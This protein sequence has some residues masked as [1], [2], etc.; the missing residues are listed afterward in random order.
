MHRFTIASAAAAALLATSA[1]AQQ[2][3]TVRANVQDAQGKPAGTVTL[4]QYPR[5]V[6][7]RA[8]LSGLPPGW[9]GFHVHQTGKCEAPGFQSAGG[10]F[11]A[12]GHKH[13]F[14]AAGTH[15]GDLPNI[16]VGADGKAMVEHFTERFRIA[17]A[18]AAAAAAS[19]MSVQA[20]G[21][22]VSIGTAGA[23]NVPPSILDQD[24][25]SVVVHANP[26]DYRTDPA[27]DSGARIACGVIERGR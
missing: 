17:E 25:A 24:G 9:H 6:L 14:E 23:T 12:G 8:E 26:D 4:A 16:H 5:G 27:G 20:G 11:D 15:A 3:A 18:G 22:T 7:I 2:P 10:H 19:G 13:G 1:S 21:G